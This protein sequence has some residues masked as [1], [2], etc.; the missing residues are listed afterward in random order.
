[1]RLKRIVSYALVIFGTAYASYCGIS[2][3]QKISV[4]KNIEPKGD[5]L[6]NSASNIKPNL[7][8]KHPKLGE[9]FADL[10]IPRL[11]VQ[12]PIIEGTDD[13]GLARGVGHYINSALPGEPDN[14]V[15][16]GHRD[17]VFRQL[18]LL[19]KDDELCVRSHGETFIYVIKKIWITDP[20]DRT[21]IVPHNKAVLTLTTCYPFSY[22]GPSPQRYIIQAELAKVTDSIVVV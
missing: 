1:M 8:K 15:L 17:T 11:K 21:V 16:S 5:M 13:R 22:I 6:L 10:I 9:H 14:A 3:I 12:I 2:Y 19:T 18:N 4:I 7:P 20:D